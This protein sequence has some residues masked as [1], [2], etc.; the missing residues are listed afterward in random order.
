MSK[1]NIIKIA[2]AILAGTILIA[3]GLR[4]KL[5]KQPDMKNESKKS[6]PQPAEYGL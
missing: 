3:V 2:S 5:L 1:N 4:K 6:N